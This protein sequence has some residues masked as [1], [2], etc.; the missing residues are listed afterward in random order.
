MK[1]GLTKNF[2][3][4]ENGNEPSSSNRNEWQLGDRSNCHK[5]EMEF[6][7]VIRHHNK[8]LTAFLPNGSFDEKCTNRRSHTP[9]LIC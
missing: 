3:G 6:E 2:L 8:K 5:S 1:L 7:F 9:L 4:L